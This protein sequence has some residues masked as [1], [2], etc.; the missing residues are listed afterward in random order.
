MGFLMM[1]FS[2]FQR[3]GPG[4]INTWES[5]GSLWGRVIMSIFPRF[6]EGF[7]SGIPFSKGFLGVLQVFCC[8]GGGL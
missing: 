5:R 4:R 6:L 1:F 8:F 7:S 3:F 2:R